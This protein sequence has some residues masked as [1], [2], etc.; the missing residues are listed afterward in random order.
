MDPSTPQNHL[1]LDILMWDTLYVY[2]DET[3]VN[4]FSWSA[5]MSLCDIIRVKG[6]PHVGRS[7]MAVPSIYKEVHV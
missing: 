1:L 7:K 3:A 2:M 6:P 4:F 5:H